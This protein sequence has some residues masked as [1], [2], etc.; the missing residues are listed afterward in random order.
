[1]SEGDGG[2]VFRLVTRAQ[3]TA[4][5]DA[6]YADQCHAETVAALERTLEQVRERKAH[7]VAIAVIFADGSFGTRFSKVFRGVD[8]L[9]GAASRL[10]HDLNARTD[11]R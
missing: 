4:D 9:I 11:E 7:G 5:E 6:A 8:R 1:V 10:L 3:R 2:G